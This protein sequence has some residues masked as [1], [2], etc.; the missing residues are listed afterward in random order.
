M[1]E[2]IQKDRISLY[3]PSFGKKKKNPN[4]SNF[5][6]FLE[7]HLMFKTIIPH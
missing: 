2:D 3:T 4:K 6:V 7:N 5:N 1:P